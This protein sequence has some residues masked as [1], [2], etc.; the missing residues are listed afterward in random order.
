MDMQEML[1]VQALLLEAVQ[2]QEKL[3]EHAHRAEEAHRQENALL[4]QQLADLTAALQQSA[5]RL[6]RGGQRFAEDA[7][8]GIEAGSCQ[9]L[10]KNA[11]EATAWMDQRTGETLQQLKHTAE[12]TTEAARQLNRAQTT[13]VWKSLAFLAVGGVLMVAGTGAWAWNKKQEAARYQVEADLSRRIT[14]SDLVQCGEGLC[15]NVD[16]KASRAG[17][18]KQY[19]PVKS[20]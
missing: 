15:A 18:R 20:R 5:Q 1:R 10:K 3:L 4:R 13:M 6:E 9:V 14:Q 2:E 19:L 16:L 7:L 8:R 11:I 12:V 17:D